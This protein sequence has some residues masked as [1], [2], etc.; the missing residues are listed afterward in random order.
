VVL[1][2]LV[3]V[4]D[5]LLLG[6]KIVV[7]RLLGDLGFPGD[8]ADGDVLI[9]SLGEQPRRD[10]G[11]EPTRARLLELAESVTGD[12]EIVAVTGVD[13]NTIVDSKFGFGPTYA[14]R[15]RAAVPDGTVIPGT[16]RSFELTVSTTARWE[17]DQ[18]V[19]EYVFWDSA[20]MAQQIGLA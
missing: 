5:Q 7:D 13:S 3:A 15:R 12:G 9:P 17:G 2:V 16:G 4:G 1:D 19:E 8:V 14:A 18:L 20:L 11:D 6:P 10:I